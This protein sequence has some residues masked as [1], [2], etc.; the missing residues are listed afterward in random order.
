MIVRWL[1]NSA[2]ALV[3]LTHASISNAEPFRWSSSGDAASLDPHSISEGFTLSFLGNVYEGL[4]RRGKDLGLEPAL[5]TSW[6]QIDDTTWRFSLREGVTFHD[7]QAFTADDVVFSYERAS[8]ESSGVATIISSIEEIA[9]V[10]EFTVDVKTKA[11]DPILPD[12]ITNWLI[13]SR[14]W[15]EENDA[16]TASVEAQNYAGQNVNGTG[17][18]TVTFREAD[19]RTE[20]VPFDGWWDEAEHNVTQ[21]TYTPIAASGTRVAALLSGEVDLIFPVPV[22]NIDQIEAREDTSVLQGPELRTIF[23]GMDQYRDTLIG[24]DAETNPFLDERVRQA[25]YQAID[26]QAIVDKIMRGAATPAG[27]LIGPGI[28]GFDPLDN[29]RLDFDPEASKALLAEAG[30]PEGFTTAMHCP[31]DRYVN[32]EAICKAVVS[33]LA[34]VGIEVDLEAMTKSV[35][36]ERLKN[37]DSGFYLLGWTSGTYDAHHIMRFLLHTP[38]PDANLGSWNFAGYSNDE[39]D[40]LTREIGSEMNEFAREAKIAR[41]HEIIRED[42]A[43]IP[44]HQQSLAWGIRDGIDLT[45]RADDFFNLRW[46]TVE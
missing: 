5:A 26:E 29:D 17:P 32:D 8:A 19:V 22:Q 2:L 40:Q 46:V 13:M 37:G 18:F 35:Y 30:Y 43:Y 21:A 15:A 28:K 38:D 20:L 7:G 27:L 34:R 6:E 39:V 3:L 44:L 12:S 1:K 11:P 42:I 23:L 16:V 41:V 10:D 45:Q 14:G 24:S 31:N 33:M 4:V 25:V 9:A 36:F